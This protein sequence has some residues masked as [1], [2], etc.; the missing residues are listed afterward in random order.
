MKKLICLTF[1]VGMSFGLNGMED[2]FEEESPLV[3]PQVNVFERGPG[4]V[5]LNGSVGVTFDKGMSIDQKIKQLTYVYRRPDFKEGDPNASWFRQVA[6]A[7][8]ASI[9]ALIYETP[10]QVVS[11]LAVQVLSQTI[12]GWIN[13]DKTS[14]ITNLK[15]LELCKKHF[16]EKMTKMSVSSPE[17]S[18]HKQK[19]DELVKREEAL[20]KKLYGQLYDEAM[21]RSTFSKC[22]DFIARVLNLQAT[23]N[24]LNY[25]LK[26]VSPAA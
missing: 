6:N 10:S 20:E 9:P 5:N 17:Y 22:G 23:K 18:E 24:N 25:F 11:S 4:A 14:E 2:S 16:V 26:K 21:G 1:L 3:P 7:A 19:I 8:I 12:L 13:G 15:K